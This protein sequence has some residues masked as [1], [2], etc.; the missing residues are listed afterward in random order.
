[1]G[2]P[3]TLPPLAMSLQGWADLQEDQSLPGAVPTSL[4]RQQFHYQLLQLTLMAPKRPA[5]NKPCFLSGVK[6]SIS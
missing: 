5:Q 4:S 1:M 2:L 6:Q 3:V